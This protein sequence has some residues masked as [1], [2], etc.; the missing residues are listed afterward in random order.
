MAEEITEQ[1]ILEEVPNEEA[2]PA[3]RPEHVPEKFWVDGQADYESMAKSYTQLEG[4]VGGKEDELRD[5]IINDLASEHDANIPESYELPALPD[6]ITEEMVTANPMTAWW[7]E[8]AKANGMNQEEYESGIN[9][10]VEMM[11]LQEPDIQGEM[12]KLGENANDRID[13]VNAF[14]QKSFPPDEFE[15]IQYS[16][17]TTAEGIQALE[18]IMEMSSGSGVN[19]EQYAQPEKRLT[20]DDAK[21][22]MADPRYHDPRHRDPA[23]VAKVD[24]AFRMLTS[25]R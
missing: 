8:T 16:L 2:A 23:Y 17:G 18:R 7:N 3:E 4:F 11:Q 9:T 22:M 21:S 5:K 14:A 20:L 1:E 24:A 6:G 25:G 15:V 10:Y 12:D 13:A 19:S